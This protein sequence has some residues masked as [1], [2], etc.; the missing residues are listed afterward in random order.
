V[1]DTAQTNGPACGAELEASVRDRLDLLLAQLEHRQLTSHDLPAAKEALEIARLQ[2]NS[3]PLGRALLTA[4]AAFR[5]IGDTEEAIRLGAEAVQLFALVGDRVHEGAAH[6]TVGVGLWHQRRWSESLVSLER[7]A[8]IAL[9]AGETVRQVNCL[10]MIA[11]TLGFLGNYPK[12]MA[13]YDQSLRATTGPG[14]E[15]HRL[16]ILNNKANTLLHRAR[17]TSDPAESAA[18]AAAAH[19]ILVPEAVVLLDRWAPA[20]RRSIRDTLAQSLLLRGSV[21]DALDMFRENL[22]LASQLGDDIVRASSAIG[23]GEALLELGNADESVAICG[24]ALAGYGSRLAPDYLTR[25]YLALSKAHRR[26]GQHAQALEAFQAYHDLVR[27]L[28]NMTEDYIRHMAVVI[29]LEKSKAEAAAYRRLAED[30]RLAQAKAEAANRAKS[31]F[32]SN[33]SHELR[34]PLNAIIG[35]S[36]VM[37]SEL[38]GPLS[39]RYQSYLTDIHQSGEHLLD[40]ISQ[41]LD[42]SKVEAGMMELVE[43]DV[44]LDSMIADAVVFV[45]DAAAAGGI[46][47]GVLPTSRLTV[48]VD[49]LRIK[50]SL[51]NVLSNAVKFTPA[52]GQISVNILPDA[53][54]VGIAVTDTGVGLAPEDVPRAFERFGQGGNTRATIGSGL[55]LPLTRQLIELHNGSV[56]LQSIRGQG[57]TVTMRLPAYRVVDHQ[58][59]LVIRH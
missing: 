22:D 52:G 39:P 6:Y 4:S 50:Q 24:E 14:L 31:E 26:L 54:G 47:I 19:D 27:H 51:I 48:R 18:H 57:T 2:G 34:T 44:E 55:G 21:S 35:F 23:M 41:L 42:L 13:T 1:A 7:A 29:E 25:A 17:T 30:L 45:Q 37:R 28:S 53:D 38:F 11:V 10:N 43:D 46:T 15:T 12:S 20:Y 56:S 58:R 32:F 33:M 40:L 3:R 49:P 5:A 36:E 8:A 59:P 16:L 9:A